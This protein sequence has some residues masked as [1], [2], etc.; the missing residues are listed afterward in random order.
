LA[1]ILGR[2]CET[3]FAASA[4]AH[5]AGWRRFVSAEGALSLSAWGN[6]PGKLDVSD[7]SA[8]SAIQSPCRCEARLQRCGK[9]PGTQ[10]WSG[11][12]QAI[13]IGAFGAGGAFCYRS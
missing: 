2:F 10:N 1:A 9:H 12:P 4:A 7:F 13:L 5:D 6:A 11:V 3:P 8:E